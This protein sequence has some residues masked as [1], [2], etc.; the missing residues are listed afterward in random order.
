MANENVEIEKYKACLVVKCYTQ[1]H[2]IDYTKVFAPVVRLE[3]IQLVISLTAQKGW[4]IF[5][6]LFN[7]SKGMDNFPA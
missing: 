6:N 7:C 2:G 3:T 1:K 4:T 5:G